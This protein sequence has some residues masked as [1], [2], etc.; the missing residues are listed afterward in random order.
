MGKDLKKLC[1]CAPLGSLNSLA[2]V[3]MCSVLLILQNLSEILQN[4]LPF[5]SRLVKFFFL[6]NCYQ[7]CPSLPA[8]M[9]VELMTSS[10]GSGETF[11]QLETP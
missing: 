7:A 11:L 1:L 5:P 8:S 3:G 6:E 10:E 2:F 4:A 9:T